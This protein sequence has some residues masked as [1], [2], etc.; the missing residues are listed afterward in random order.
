[1]KM[2]SNQKT[3]P[4]VIHQALHFDRFQNYSFEPVP[5]ASREMQEWCFARHVAELWSFQRLLSNVW[6]ANQTDIIAESRYVDCV[7]STSSSSTLFFIGTDI[8][9]AARKEWKRRKE[10]LKNSA[11]TNHEP[12]LDGDVGAVPFD[13]FETICMTAIVD[14]DKLYTDYVNE[15]TA[16]RRALQGPESLCLNEFEINLRKYRIIGGVFCVEYFEQP[17]QDTKHSS[18]SYLRTSKRAP[19]QSERL[20]IFGSLILQSLV[21]IHWSGAIFSNTTEHRHQCR[22]ACDVYPKSWRPKWKQSKV[23]WIN[24]HTLRYRKASVKQ[25][26]ADDPSNAIL[27]AVFRMMFCGLSRQPF[28]DGKPLKKQKRRWSWKVNRR[29]LQSFK[30]VQSQCQ[31]SHGSDRSQRKS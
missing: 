22:P 16:K 6:V 10:I 17:Q 7:I 19:I 26:S 28:A 2:I 13:N 21:R 11:N 4:D 15:L 27:F 14:V 8:S 5:A 3:I 30:R 24:W 25:T 18:N 23:V 20:L 31:A 1:M 29:T 12:M 9:I